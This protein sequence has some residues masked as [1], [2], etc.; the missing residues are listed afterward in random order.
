MT[1]FWSIWKN[2]AL[3]VVVWAAWRGENRKQAGKIRAH[4]LSRLHPLM[5]RV[6]PVAAAAAGFVL[7]ALLRGGQPPLARQ[8]VS[9][10]PA[11]PPTGAAKPSVSRRVADAPVALHGSLRAKTA[12]PPAP[13]KFAGFLF[14]AG[15]GKRLN[16]THGLYLVAMLS[17]SC[18]GC[19][20]TMRSLNRLVDN[21]DLPPLVGFVLGGNEELTRFRALYRPRFSMKALAPVDFLYRIGSAPPR[22]LLIRDGRELQHWDEKLP[23]EVILVRAVLENS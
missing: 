3:L 22:F 2:V 5:G 16:L 7:F 4:V 1:P 11:L 6:L 8:P 9:T 23:E 10:P 12:R 13:G 19:A 15:S 21:R 18:D 20:D 14:D 17:D